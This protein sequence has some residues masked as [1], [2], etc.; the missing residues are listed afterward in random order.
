MNSTP[1]KAAQEMLRILKEHTR[2]VDRR[3][4]PL[5]IVPL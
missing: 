1:T 3:S 4:V 5:T 2:T